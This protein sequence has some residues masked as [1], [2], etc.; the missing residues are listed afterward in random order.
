MEPSILIVDDHEIVREGVRSLV[1]SFRPD[2]KIVGEAGSGMEA[3]DAISRL[4]PDVVILDITMPGMSG[5]Q[6]GARLREIGTNSRIL[7]FTMHNSQS[8]LRDIRG[9]GGRGYVLKSEAAKNLIR[10][11]ETIYAGGAFFG[12]PEPGAQGGGSLEP[13]ILFP[14]PQTT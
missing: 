6:V 8:L 1:S 9:A 13:G 2:W 5:L 14:R 10:A 11:I 3:V 4:Q 12:E 7:F